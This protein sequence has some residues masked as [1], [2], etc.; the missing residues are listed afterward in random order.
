MKINNYKISSH[1]FIVLFFAFA[2]P[3]FYSFSE[4]AQK[5]LKPVRYS[6]EIVRK[7]EPAGQNSYNFYFNLEI[8]SIISAYLASPGPDGD[9]G[10]S[11][12][13]YEL[14]TNRIIMPSDSECVQ[15]NFND[16]FKK[17]SIIEK[18]D[19][20]DSASFF[21][22][23]NASKYSV[24]F[25]ISPAA[26]VEKIAIGMQGRSSGLLSSP[27]GIACDPSGN[28]F[29]AD[30]GN[31]RIQ[32]FDS[33]GH[34]IF[35]F[36]SF[37]WDEKNTSPN[38]V[39]TSNAATF[40]EPVG[41]AVTNKN[42]FVSER[43]NNR[44]QKFDRDGNFLL[45]FGGEGNMRGR[46]SS[47]GGIACDSSNY[48]WVCDTKN[49]RVQK[50]DQNGNFML[51][52]GGFGSG[53]GKFNEPV[54][55]AIDSK[56]NI[57]ILDARNERV[58]I[59]DEY[60]NIR[61][62]ISLEKLKGMSEATG[63]GVFLDRIVLVSSVFEKNSRIAAFSVEGDFFGFIGGEHERL[64]AIAASRDGDIYVSE[65]ARHKILKLSLPDEKNIHNI[66][67]LEFCK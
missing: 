59:C 14:F 25:E 16:A 44:I 52:I 26:H 17:Y 3:L 24:M 40:N 4:A 13:I 49:D 9:S 32:K 31:D 33:S 54:D 56:N 45:I 19:E 30:Y 12:K 38:N 48:V 11:L 37:A 66:N 62:T 36:G 57:Y 63:V 60:G 43:G 1:L 61:S 27:R 46:L 53:E 20:N 64:S 58:V 21:N 65:N 34:F 29:V 18:K 8:Q 15:I 7:I 42:I 2:A 23:E 28:I 67:L 5:P 39:G 22:K 35:E 50:F 55:L 10:K 41:V 51:E 47:P 6:S